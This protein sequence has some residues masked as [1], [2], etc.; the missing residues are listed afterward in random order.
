MSNRA[1]VYA[2]F[3]TD[4]QSERSAEDQITLCRAY[5]DRE[6]YQVVAAYEDKAK[7]GAS[8]FGRY[9]LQQLLADA[10]NQ[11]FDV[12]IVEALD[13]L[14]RDMEDLAGMHKRMSFLGIKI[15]AVHEGEANTVIVGLR[16]SSAS[17]SV[18]ITYIRFVVGWR[19]V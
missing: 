3:S 12:I 14:A 1:A 5:A 7:S 10:S 11:K 6:G 8:M 15:I 19:A 9:G 16:G 17:C 4:L 2:R 18:R 13:R